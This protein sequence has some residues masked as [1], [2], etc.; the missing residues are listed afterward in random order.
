MYVCL[1]VTYFF[2]DLAKGARQGVL[3]LANMATH[4]ASKVGPGQISAQDPQP[5]L[6][7]S[8]CGCAMLEAD[9]VLAT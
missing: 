9:H 6:R 2:D 3:T 1:C 5:R 8:N 7:V 4:V